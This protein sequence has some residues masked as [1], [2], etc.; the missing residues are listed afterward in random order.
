MPGSSDAPHLPRSAPIEAYGKG[1]FAFAVTRDHARK[2][3]SVNV[4]FIA[5]GAGFLIGAAADFLIAAGAGF[6]TWQ[7]LHECG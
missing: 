5:A 1:G 6:F 4:S 7:T 2:S 3:S